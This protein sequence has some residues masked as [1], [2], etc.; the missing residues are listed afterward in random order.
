M[1]QE[2]RLITELKRKVLT[3]GVIEEVW[4]YTQWEFSAVDGNDCKFPSN[5]DVVALGVGI[6]GVRPPKNRLLGIVR[7]NE[8]KLVVN[9]LQHTQLCALDEFTAALGRQTI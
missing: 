9:I 7:R 5:E 4:R 3:T 8:K 1:E 6:L 2:R